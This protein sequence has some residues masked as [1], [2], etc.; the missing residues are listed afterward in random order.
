VPVGGQGAEDNKQR[1]CEL[2]DSGVAP[3]LTGYVLDM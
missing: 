1:L 2:V 3:G